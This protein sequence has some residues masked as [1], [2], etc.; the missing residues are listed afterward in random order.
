MRGRSA[1]DSVSRRWFRLVNLPNVIIANGLSGLVY[2]TNF[3][4][5]LPSEPVARRRH[6]QHEK[7]DATDERQRARTAEFRV[8]NAN[9]DDND[10]KQKNSDARDDRLDQRLPFH[11]LRFRRP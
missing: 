5:L 7:D 3:S 6:H 8:E 11:V 1:W 2:A 10:E 4:T 9:G